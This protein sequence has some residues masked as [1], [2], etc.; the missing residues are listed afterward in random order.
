MRRGRFHF[1]VEMHHLDEQT[2]RM[3]W[4]FFSATVLRSSHKRTE[5]LIRDTGTQNSSSV[6]F[7]HT[8]RKGKSVRSF[9][10][11]Q[12]EIDFTAQAVIGETTMND[13]IGDAE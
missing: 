9:P 8:S 2:Q 10:N 11:G 5:E 6:F 7:S 12:F 4:T 1:Y 3:Q 13:V